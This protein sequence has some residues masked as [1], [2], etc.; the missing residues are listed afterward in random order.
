MSNEVS[1]VKAVEMYA[2]EQINL[3]G[4][5]NEKGEGAGCAGGG[6]RKETG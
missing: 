4:R 1:K 6:S 5:I 2:E 3:G